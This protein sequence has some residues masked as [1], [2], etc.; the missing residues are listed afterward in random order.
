MKTYLSL[1]KVLFKENFSLKRLFGFDFKKEKIKAILIGLAIVYTVFI[2]FGMMTYLFYDLGEFLSLI[3]RLDLILVFLASYAILFSVFLALLR[4][5]G[6]IFHYKD[7]TILGALPIDSKI[8]LVTKLS[9][10]F[11]MIYAM[12]FLLSIPIIIS[13]FYWAGFH[14]IKLIMILIGLV[15][16]PIF[17]VL[18]G[19]F[20]SLII[21]RITV[22]VRYAN[23]LNILLMVILLAAFFIGSF[24]LGSA[25][26]ENPLIGQ[27]NFMTSLTEY[28]LPLRWFQEGVHEINLLQIFGVV[29]LNA[30]PI[31]LF[32]FLA[33]DF[34]N[35]TNQTGL[36]SIQRKHNKTAVSQSRSVIRT[37]VHKEFRKFF[38]LPI[39]VL[40]VGIG[41]LF[42][43]IVPIIGLIYRS[44]IESVL[45]EVGGAETTI[46]LGILIFV[47]FSLS[48]VYTSAISLSLEGKNL[49]I[50]KSLPLKAIDI[51]R[52]KAIF[53][54]WL[55]LPLAVFAVII[56]G[57]VYSVG[58]LNTVVMLL[59]II[60]FSYLKTVFDTLINLHVPKL[61]FV[62]D[63]EVIKQ[64]AGALLAVFGGFALIALGGVIYYFSN[65]IIGFT[66][67]LIVIALVNLLLS[68]IITVYVYKRCEVLIYNMKI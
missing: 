2:L 50:L 23:Y 60:V 25:D 48:M 61:D 21:A 37:L 47:S 5:N 34:V 41:P 8:L 35:R 64:S 9:M 56:L 20:I 51:V 19:S 4:S 63:V 18:V 67:S 27:Q 11:V 36:G 12:I 26:L 7:Y 45:I 32:V 38:S 59:S 17:P 1:M 44:S 62:N 6:Y 65:E 29:M 30:L 39:Y 10:M 49:W 46:E 22:R 31:F 53:N 13:Y 33:Y 68:F 3:N 66:W 15:F 54:L 24:T 58:V 55:G 43:L 42:L 52:A 28:Y 16:L 57:F 40:N 14:F